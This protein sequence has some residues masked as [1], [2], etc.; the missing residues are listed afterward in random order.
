MKSIMIRTPDSRFERIKDFPYRANYL[1]TENGRVHYIDEGKGEVILA[2]HGEPTWAY[3]YRK[4]IP[5]LSLNNRF[6]AMDFIGFG[7][8]DKLRK[9]KDYSYEMHLDTLAAFVEKLGIERINLVVQDWGG[10][11]GLGFLGQRPEL[12]KSIVIMNTFLPIG[13]RPMN[14]AF[15]IWKR[16]ARFHPTLPI[17]S[18]VKW[19]CYRKGNFT[20]EIN[21]A[22]NAPFPSRKYKAGPRSFPQLV[23]Q[24]PDDPGVNYMKKAREVLSQWNKPCLVLFSDKDPIMT[25]AR[26]FFMNLVPTAKDQQEIWIR[27]ASHFLQEDAGEEIA[28]YINQFLKGKLIVSN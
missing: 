16:Y 24:K 25:P 20:K 14:K 27:K 13:D 23:P 7:R 2:L 3:L 22:Y 1:D 17:G 8:S 28:G 10:F 18:I 9:I 26:K 19:G 6:I 11:I 12:F 21:Y 5:E 4:L 15:R